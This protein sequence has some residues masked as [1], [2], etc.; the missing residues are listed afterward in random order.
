MFPLEVK[1]W[2]LQTAKP[3]QSRTGEQAGLVPNLLL[4]DRL[5]PSF[6]QVHGKFKS[7]HS[8]QNITPAVCNFTSD[9]ANGLE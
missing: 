9:A 7:R 2:G 4:M 6:A 5:I 3:G 8:N 1:V